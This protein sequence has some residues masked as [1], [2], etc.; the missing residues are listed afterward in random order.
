MLRTKP[1][2]PNKHKSY[3][4]VVEIMKEVDATSVENI[5]TVCVCLKVCEERFICTLP[6]V[7]SY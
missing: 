2:I 3:E 7:I 4:R 1:V 6:H 5:Q